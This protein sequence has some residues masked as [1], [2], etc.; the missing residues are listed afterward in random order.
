M[1]LGVHVRRLFTS[2][3]LCLVASCTDSSGPG[4]GALFT[5]RESLT[6]ETVRLQ[7]A[8]P[9]GVSDAE[10]LLRSGEEGWVLGTIRG[11]D[12][13][14]NAPYTWHLD[15]ESVSFAEVTIEACQTRAAAIAEDLD[16]WVAFG[17]VCIWGVVET[18]SR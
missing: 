11:G 16:Y 3:I 17:Q 15:P 2:C 8:D 18:R 9:S 5:F 4:G 7:I 14:F 12:G 13:G 6:A 1:L 10:S